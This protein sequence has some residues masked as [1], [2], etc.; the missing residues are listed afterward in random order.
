EHLLRVAF[1]ASD[2]TRLL[3]QVLIPARDLGAREVGQRPL[4]PLHPERATA[5]HD[6]PEAVADDGDAGGALDDVADTLDR[7]RGAGVERLLLGVKHGTALDRRHL[8]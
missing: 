2:L 5:L 6:R 7:L 3:G 4:V 1:L 8:R